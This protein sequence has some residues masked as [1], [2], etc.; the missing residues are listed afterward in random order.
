LKDLNDKESELYE[1][2]IKTIQKD[3]DILSMNQR[4]QAVE[5]QTM[6]L[7]TERDKLID[8]SNELKG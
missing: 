8:I 3:N 7:R 4:L 1:L 5:R 2:K 6:T